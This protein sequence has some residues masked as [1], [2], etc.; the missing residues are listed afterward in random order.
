MEAVSALPLRRFSNGRI[1]LETTGAT[2][3]GLRRSHNEDTLG[4]LPDAY[5]A[6]ERQQG[7]LF[8]VADGMGGAQKGEVASHV[9]VDTLF[10]TYYDRSP[11]SAPDLPPRDALRASFNAANDAVY[12]QGL[13]L[14]SGMMGTTLVACA[15]VEDTAIVANVGD[16]RAYLIRGG[17]IR[18]ISED[19][20]FVAEQVK[21]G[22]LSPEEARYS[23]QR[24]IITRAIGHEPRLQ[25]D[26]YEVGPLQPG[27]VLLLCSDGLHG[28]IEDADLL[29]I[30]QQ[31]D[32]QQA[33][34]EYVALANAHGGL[35]NITCLLV[36]ILP[37]DADAPA[38]NAGTVP[39]S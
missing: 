3:V 21:A 36:R 37:P 30:G 7:F 17:Q 27:D 6:R 10:A 11:D 33:A 28:L 25:T 2:H 13:T 16:S 32:L 26:Q 12:R 22:V 24:N 8:A 1:G 9:A 20:S 14:E 19:H 5:R 38:E 4:L 15:I 34:R 23:P 29:A 31:A 18:Q 35:D 39:A